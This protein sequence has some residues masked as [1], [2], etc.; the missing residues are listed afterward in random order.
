[1]VLTYLKAAS[2]GIKKNE[3]SKN[4]KN[5]NYLVKKILDY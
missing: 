2:L 3:N 1:M 5:F 4:S